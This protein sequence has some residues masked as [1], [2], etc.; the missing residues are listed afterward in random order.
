MSHVRTDRKQV[1]GNEEL[2]ERYME[3]I[4]DIYNARIKAM[5]Q[6]VTMPLTHWVN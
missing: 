4:R 5:T 6:D 3:K 2:D 1:F